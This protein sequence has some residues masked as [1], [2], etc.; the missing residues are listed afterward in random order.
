MDSWGRLDEDSLGKMA[1]GMKDKL[2]EDTKDKLVWGK[3]DK[4][5]QDKLLGKLEEDKKP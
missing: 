4:M 5:V 2:V 1:W 3:M